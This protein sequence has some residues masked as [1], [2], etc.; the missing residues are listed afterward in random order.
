MFGLVMESIC[1]TYVGCMFL[2]ALAGNMESVMGCLG[3]VACLNIPTAVRFWMTAAYAYSASGKACLEESY[4]GKVLWYYAT[5]CLI[6]AG[7]ICVLSCLCGCIMACC[8]AKLMGQMEGGEAEAE[9][10]TKD[11]A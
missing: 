11:G 1:V 2:G 7:S 9:P 4:A 10:S 6:T 5:I 3:C 8:G